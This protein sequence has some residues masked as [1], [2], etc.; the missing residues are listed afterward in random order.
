LDYGFRG[1]PTYHG[2]V[3]GYGDYPFTVEG[4][5]STQYVIRMLIQISQKISIQVPNDF[6]TNAVAKNKFSYYNLYNEKD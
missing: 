5:G 1:V 6:V 4:E 2:S 3:F